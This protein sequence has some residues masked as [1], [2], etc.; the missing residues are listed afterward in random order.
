MRR[1]TRG[2][3]IAVEG[4]VG[5]PITT[6]AR[7]LVRA[8]RAD[9]RIGLSTWDSS[10]IFTELAAAG[11]DVPAASSRTLTLLYAAD[12]AFRLRW[13]IEPALE[14]GLWVVAAPYVETAVAL[15]AAAGVRKRWLAELF[16]FAPKPHA[17]YHAD[18]RDLHAN[19][20]AQ[21]GYPEFFRHTL[22]AGGRG[23]AAAD[24]LHDRSLQYLNQLERRGRCDTLTEARLAALRKRRRVPEAKT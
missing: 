19:R 12:L 10:G 20:R 7:D 8:L 5:G 23:V 22:R 3:L 11:E 6:T 13:Q 15:A 17:C 2:C 24:G 18:D 4:N 1:G 14:A 21:A 9:G 16:R